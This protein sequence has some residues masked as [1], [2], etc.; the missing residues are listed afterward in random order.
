M[1][2]GDDD[3]RTRLLAAGAGRVGVGVAHLDDEQLEPLVVA[4]VLAGG[5]LVAFLRVALLVEVRKLGLHPVAYLD[6]GEVGRA[7]QH[8]AGDQ[9]ADAVGELL[10]DGL[11]AR[12][13]TCA[14]H[15][16]SGVGSERVVFPEYSGPPCRAGAE[17]CPGAS[18]GDQGQV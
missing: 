6:D 11:A 18:V 2:A 16:R 8:R 13:G 17:L 4:V 1:G 10:V 14:V 5:T 15:G 7:L 3:G 12:H 9:V